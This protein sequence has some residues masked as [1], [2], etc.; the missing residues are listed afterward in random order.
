[1]SYLGVPADR[2]TEDFCK[3]STLTNANSKNALWQ[4]KTLAQILVQA[5]RDPGRLILSFIFLI[6]KM[7]ITTCL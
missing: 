4:T 5:L 3:I 2:M 7:G 1:M 6:C